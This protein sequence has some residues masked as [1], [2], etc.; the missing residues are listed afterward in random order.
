MTT[1]SL[2]YSFVGFALQLMPATLLL[3]L[4]FEPL[5]YRVQGKRLWTIFGAV[6]ISLTTIYAAG[7]YGILL[8]EPES[9][10]PGL[11]FGNYFMLFS[12]V[13]VAA[14]YFMLNLDQPMRKLFLLFIVV[15][16]AVVQYSL[17]VMVLQLQFFSALGFQY[18]QNYDRPT[19]IAYLVITTVLLPPIAVFF[20]KP[21]RTYLKNMDAAYSR[22]EFILLVVFTILYLAINA[23]FSTFWE[24]LRLNVNV[25]SI[26][27][28]PTILLLTSMLF[29]VYYSVIRFANLRVIEGEWQL[30]AAI[31]EE[32]YKRI[33]QDMEKQ[34]ER[35]HDTRQLL[36]SLYVITQNGSP[37]ELLAYINE[38][39]DHIHI[40]DKRFCEDGRLN[41][42]LQYYDSLAAA[43]GIPF[44]VHAHCLDL[45]SIPE[46]DLTVLLGN[47]L[48]NAI[49]S[50]K[51]WR[52][53]HPE[54]P[55]AIRFNADDTQNMLRIQIENPSNKVAYAI[56][57]NNLNVDKYMPAEAFLSTSG[58][59]QGLNRIASIAAKYEGIA[60]FRYNEK[61][62][63]FITRIT[64]I[65]PESDR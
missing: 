51:A 62:R 61:T 34:S 39:I 55:T 48:E 11:L 4:P 22:G 64:L 12:A 37:E 63:Q 17:V 52:A 44:D 57:V 46:I 41:G 56:P 9:S 16:F 7:T 2:L 45:S 20:R 35:L 65:V 33:K 42:I 28:I 18:T 23:L 10:G 15:T 59:G 13:I 53:D 30:T 29:V 38:T 31:I 24:R 26:Y 47:A 36:R 27:N 50:T 49:R 8:R 54:D 14:L 40:T 6:D 19:C 25:S 43:S 5:R 1:D 58:G 21:L 3:L 60:N 32:D